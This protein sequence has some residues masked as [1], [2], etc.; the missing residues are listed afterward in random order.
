[1]IVQILLLLQFYICNSQTLRLC[2]AGEYV[3]GNTCQNCTVGKYMDLP[4]HSLSSC[5]ECQSGKVQS[6]EKQSTCQQC[7]PGTIP[8]AQR[9]I[10]QRCQSGTFQ[11]E[12]GR[13]VCKDCPVGTH[14]LAPICSDDTKTSE[15]E[16][17]YQSSGYVWGDDS[18]C[19]E[20]S[21]NDT[22]FTTKFDCEDGYGTWT[23][24]Q[25]NNLQTED[26]CIYTETSN[27]WSNTRCTD[28]TADNRMDCL[29]ERNTNTWTSDRTLCQDCP[30]GFYQ[31]KTRHTYCNSCPAGFQQSNP[32][33]RFCTECNP[34]RFQNREMATNCKNCPIN[35]YQ[36][37]QGGIECTACALGQYTAFE[38]STSCFDCP[39]TGDCCSGWGLDNTNTCQPCEAGAVRNV[40]T[41]KCQQCPP[42]S[43]SIKNTSLEGYDTCESCGNFTANKDKCLS[44]E[45]DCP[46]G[47]FA[48]DGYCQ[49]CH[50]GTYRITSQS[51]TQSTTCTTCP[52]GWYNNDS[53]ETSCVPCQAGTTN[54]TAHTSCTNCT[55]GKKSRT[56]G[57]C[58]TTCTGYS[59]SIGNSIGNECSTCGDGQYYNYSICTDCPIGWIK[60]QT[61]IASN[62]ACVECPTGKVNNINRTQCQQCETGKQ[63]NSTNCEDCQPGKFNPT[64]GGVC[65]VCSSGQYQDNT[66]Q[67]ACD[68]CEAGQYRGDDDG[69][70]TT[71]AAG[72][73]AGQ[74]QRTCTDCPIGW[75]NADGS[76]C[77]EQIACDTVTCTLCAD[78]KQM[79]DTKPY[80][81]H[82]CPRGLYRDSQV[83]YRGK[84]AFCPAGYLQ[85]EPGK[86]TCIQ[87]NQDTMYSMASD[88][89]NEG[90]V[91]CVSQEICKVGQALQGGTTCTNCTDGTYSIGSGAACKEC[92]RGYISTA[93][94]GK[95]TRCRS[96]QEP[97]SAGTNCQNCTK[98]VSQFGIC[99][100]CP[101]GQTTNDSI[102]CSPCGD[103][104]T[105]ENGRCKPC[106]DRF[107]ILKDGRCAY[108]P[109]GRYNPN[110][111]IGAES[112]CIECDNGEE[113]TMSG[114]TKQ[115]TECQAG[116]YIDGTENYCQTCPVGYTSGTRATKCVQCSVSC[117]GM[118][119]GG[120]YLVASECKKCPQ[121]YA[122]PGIRQTFCSQCTAGREQP[123]SGESVCHDCAPG[124]YSTN[125]VNIHCELCPTGQYQHLVKQGQC[126][127]CR[128]GKYT[129]SLGQITC[130]TCALGTYS[131]DTGAANEDCKD[132]P[133][134][135]QG[136]SDGTCAKCPESTY[137]DQ[138][139]QTAC[140]KC[141]TGTEPL[142]RPAATDTTDCFEG[143]GLTSY[144]FDVET[145]GKKSA[146]Y[147]SRCEIRPN[148]VL[149]C[150]GCSCNDNARD[151]YWDGPVCDE[152]RHGFA[153]GRVGK[154]LIKCPGY[155]GVHDS[156]MCGGNGKCWFGKYGSGECLCGGKNVL[157]ASSNNIVVNVKTCP[158][159]QRC[160][161]YGN[162]VLENT[163]YIPF[164]YILEYRQYS[165][166][167]LQLNLYTPERGHMWFERYS[168]QTIYEN[169]CATCTGS[170]DGTE[171]TQIGH[172]SHESSEYTFFSPDIQVKNGFHGENCQHECAMCLNSGHCLH[173]PHP[174]YYSYSIANTHETFSEVF[175]PQT[176]CI[177]SSDIYD[178]DAMCCPHGF[179]PYVYFGKRQV[180]PYF[181]HTALPFITNLVND[182]KTYWTDEDL[183][184]KNKYPPYKAPSGNTITVS[185]LNSAYEENTNRLGN[186]EV[187]YLTYGPY[188]KHVFYGTE[189]EICRACPGLFGKGVVSRS[190]EITSEPLAEDFWWDSAAKGKK[191]NGL[192]VCDFYLQRF[193]SD[194][195]LFMG[196]VKKVEDTKYKLEKRFTGCAQQGT[197]LGKYT[198]IVTLGKYTGIVNCIANNTREVG[199]IKISEPYYISGYIG[200]Q[201]IVGV[202]SSGTPA[203]NSQ[204]PWGYVE[205]DQQMYEM[206]QTSGFTS[207]PVPDANGEY[208]FHPWKEGECWHVA[209]VCTPT[210]EKMY[211]IYKIGITGQGE[212]RLTSATFDRFD[213][214][215]TYDDGTF[216]TK[217]G[218]Y[219]TETYKNGQDPFLGKNCPKGHFCTKTG[220]DFDNSVGF[221]EAC[222][223]GYYQPNEAETR[224]HPDIMCSR[225]QISG[226]T[227]EYQNITEGRCEDIVSAQG[228][229]WA[230][231]ETKTTCETAAGQ[232][233]S[234]ATATNTP[235][236]GCYY[237]SG[238]VYFNDRVSSEPCSATHK[239]TCVRHGPCQ[240]HKGTQD[241][242]DLVDSV[243]I[244]CKRNEYSKE[245][246]AKCTACPQGRVKKISSIYGDEP[247]DS[248]TMLNMPSNLDSS[249]TPWYFIPE[250]T[251]VE[252]SDCALVPN[253]I[254]HVPKADTHMNYEVP[255]FLP[256]VSCPFGYSSRPGTYVIW[257]HDKVVVK[258]EQSAASGTSFIHAPFIQDKSTFDTNSD[259]TT[260]L[261]L[262]LDYCFRCPTNA[263]TSAGSMT[264]ATCF[265]NTLKFY[266]KDGIGQMVE[267]TSLGNVTDW[268]FVADYHVPALTYTLKQRGEVWKS[269]K[270]P[271]YG[272]RNHVI[273][274]T[275]YGSKITD[276]SDPF[277]FKDFETECAVRC[278]NDGHTKFYIGYFRSQKVPQH[279]YP[280][281]RGC[282]CSSSSSFRDSPY[283]S[284]LSTTYNI[285]N[286]S[287]TGVKGETYST[288][289]VQ[290]VNEVIQYCE[291][292]YHGF[293][294]VSINN[295]MNPQTK[296]H[297][298]GS[299]CCPVDETCQCKG[300][301]IGNH[302]TG[303]LLEND[304]HCSGDGARIDCI[305]EQICVGSSN[306]DL[307]AA[308]VDVW[309]L[310]KWDNHQLRPQYNIA[311]PF[312]LT[313][314]PI[315]TWSTSSIHFTVVNNKTRTIPSLGIACIVCNAYLDDWQ[316]VG[317]N[318]A[319]GEVVC[320]YH[321]SSINYDWDVADGTQLTGPFINFGNPLRIMYKVHIGSNIW[322]VALVDGISPDIFLKMVK[323]EITGRNTFTVLA[324]RYRPWSEVKDICHDSFSAICFE[325]FSG[326]TVTIQQLAPKY[327]VNLVTVPAE[328]IPNG[329]EV[330]RK[331]IVT[332]APSWSISAFPLCAA[333]S[334][335][336]KTSSTNG[337]C[338]EC[339]GGKYTATMSDASLGQCK[340]CPIGYHQPSTGMTLCLSCKPGQ[341]QSEESKLVCIDCPAG[342]SQSFPSASNCTGCEPGETQAV[343]G[344]TA[345]NWCTAG[346]Y[347]PNPI[348]TNTVCGQCPEG[349]AQPHDQYPDCD[350]CVG[351][352]YQDGQGASS[353]KDCEAGTFSTVEAR[354]TACDPCPIGKFVASTSATDCDWCGDDGTTYQDNPRSTS[355][356]TCQAGSSCS[357]ESSNICAAGKYQKIEGNA[358]SV[359]MEC[360]DGFF[361]AESS[362]TSCQECGDNQVSEGTSCQDCEGYS[363]KESFENEKYKSKSG[364]HSQNFKNIIKH[365]DARCTSDTSCDNQNKMICFASWTITM[366]TKGKVCFKKNIGNVGDGLAIYIKPNGWD[367]KSY[368][369]ACTCSAKMCTGTSK[370]N[371]G[372]HDQK[373]RTPFHWKTS[374]WPTTGRGSQTKAPT[375]VGFRQTTEKYD[376]DL[377]D[378]IWYQQDES[379]YTNDGKS[380]FNN[381]PTLCSLNE[382]ALGTRHV[383]VLI[384]YG[385]AKSNW[386]GNTAGVVAEP[387][388]FKVGL[389]HD[390]SFTAAG[391]TTGRDSVAQNRC[392]LS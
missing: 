55:S 354:V 25:L 64:G 319:T 221:K 144:V 233:V 356:K 360:D 170:Y 321:D 100:A 340:K 190:V 11:N 235:P 298:K 364:D 226:I 281:E 68:N 270:P 176:Q 242:N 180:D 390:L 26:D 225:L 53:G 17:I 79:S 98:G 5:K 34:G 135:W 4:S 157:D 139:G 101:V 294:G 290:T 259:G 54:N 152:C 381:D 113:L 29:Y 374:T 367:L 263:M 255:A 143:S 195:V 243:C 351:G 129:N 65:R 362:A 184:L 219:V 145:D 108:C 97:D 198:G 28:T 85:S 252:M 86:S 128:P 301:C 103:F 299:K 203:E 205:K 9:A 304:A 377:I 45:S 342:Y 6:R 269:A 169:V 210:K 250:E 175:V 50:Q 138:Q 268:I 253:G 256:V 118:C 56:G 358:G 172:F 284:G 314:S 380:S 159:G 283:G 279:I 295:V 247:I 334:P 35:S 212:D 155:D 32:A 220:H 76:T 39:D 207:V 134:G 240:L 375:D 38:V 292:N 211:S 47:T 171:Y 2:N 83:G 15:D 371:T 10:C 102:V 8:G 231:I 300:D 20:Y 369:D 121:G 370:H 332:P 200:Q 306:G 73:Y 229:T 49:P 391:H 341:Y 218:N 168:P 48:S 337:G 365:G 7:L 386:P 161:G 382:Y 232:N 40:T 392:L 228:W 88:Q 132:C 227:K 72:K 248:L 202:R 12:P 74:G 137:Q 209:G 114:S 352:T 151:G 123:I 373:Y 58:E 142:S 160:S 204:A 261:P 133:K 359:C 95:C 194:N 109:A 99:A 199:T 216:K 149:L 267:S 77:T 18:T 326:L 213:T 328:E 353:C 90:F 125:S 288:A 60:S 16:C 355:C 251:G 241:P 315:D 366:T 156:T 115:C 214:C 257:G 278:K 181:H 41:N 197:P 136:I 126:N 93:D 309:D 293:T 276:T 51:T 150:P 318:I 335:G 343:T 273:S 215:F 322:I 89:P 379:F 361:A 52:T 191:C 13:S 1:M 388:N 173:V 384:Y 272:P 289:T 59:Q 67:S 344:A 112:A 287:R 246:S 254:I 368:W 117:L 96:G 43:I 177:C 33:Q 317:F 37:R 230:D 302:G 324:S 389:Y 130:K 179:E 31:S 363:W 346:R 107:D 245:G 46:S 307:V 154:C 262:A 291:A 385:G 148:M 280:H 44:D 286:I 166:F 111:V 23:G 236:R 296:C 110:T 187:E 325:A 376:W 131:D 383:I 124:K 201:S 94:K 329:F 193:E 222:P 192:G 308:T 146:V 22:A 81:C 19:K 239:C 27:T 348:S 350:Q 14:G 106:A 62:G 249:F 164:Y 158:A 316:E 78:G 42:Q 153:G 30:R 208:L 313:A 311:T 237:N 387:N 82:D 297:D 357:A 163:K 331:E 305:F 167:V 122:S 196:D 244:R 70:C 63:L 182:R 61:M 238:S 127:D 234:N 141:T 274:P 183:W 372:K 186:E 266:L 285:E 271:S 224:Q 69:H 258:L 24:S 223:A 188:T 120:H 116:K 260:H 265:A 333:C 75:G 310:G 349:W 277:Y 345:C 174:F 336:Q 36:D 84:C 66:G 21:C 323:I 338:V 282:S 71:C 119:P 185:N 87:C 327:P 339:V 189:K 147:T 165:V 57:M 3:N 80:Q 275:E 303:D 264:C 320:A 91:A 162:E 140:K 92:P 312:Q 206:N 330:Y 105:T 378:R 347:E 178:A 104:K 217:I